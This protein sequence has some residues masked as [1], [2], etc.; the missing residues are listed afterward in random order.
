[1]AN[2]FENLLNCTTPKTEFTFNE[3]TEQPNEALPPDRKKI[4]ES[5]KD[6]KASGENSIIPEHRKNAN[7]NFAEKLTKI[8]QKILVTEE[9][10]QDWETALNH[11]LHD[12][13]DGI[14]LFTSNSCLKYYIQSIA[15]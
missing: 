15:K 13:G 7:D 3:G 6:N 11:P 5:P 10:S 8:I 12:K 4:I 9:V 2:Y 14:R 1:M